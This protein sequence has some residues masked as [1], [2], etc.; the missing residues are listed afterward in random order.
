M[1]G[2]WRTGNGRRADTVGSLLIGVP[3]GSGALTYVGRVGSGFSDAELD[4]MT[5]LFAEMAREDCPLDGVPAID[6]RD[7]HWIDPDLVGEVSYGEWTEDHRLRH[8]AW[9]GWRVDKA[10]EDVVV[11]TP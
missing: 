2:G 6:A 3:D 1:I 8:P 4:R 10:P 11:E 5:E 9:R 7:A